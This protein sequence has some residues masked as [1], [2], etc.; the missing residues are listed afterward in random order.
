MRRSAA[1]F[2][3][4]LGF[5]VSACMVL[6]L[7]TRQV[8]AVVVA[9]GGYGFSVIGATLMMDRLPIVRD[10]THF[11]TPRQRSLL[12]WVCIAFVLTGLTALGLVVAKV[13]PLVALI[14]MV[15]LPVAG[16]TYAAVLFL[17]AGR[18]G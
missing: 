5:A 2:S 6:F 9:A 14:V 13:D 11:M 10:R 4:A 7:V 15:L 18:P 17:S 3:V 1:G 16:G 12:R 8:G